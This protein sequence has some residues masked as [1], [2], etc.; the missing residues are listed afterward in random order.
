MNMHQ[1]IKYSCDVYFYD[2]ARRIGINAIAEA[3]RKFGLGETYGFEVPGEKAGLVPTPDWKRATRGEPW[4]QG[5][6]VIAGIGQG[7]LLATPLQ[8]AVMTARLA[9]GGHAVKPR[10]TRAVGGQL[11]P[12]PRPASLGVSETA[13][14][15]ACDGMNAVSNEA[16]AQLFARAFPIPVW[17]SPAR[18]V[19][20]RFAGSAALSVRP[21]SCEMKIFRGGFAT[22]RFLYVSRRC[23]HPGMPCRSSSN[24]AGRA[25]ALRHLSRGTSCAR[26]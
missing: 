16:G 13:L 7:Y 3:A 6:T 22:M 9:N 24:M 10:L 2:V 17:S 23:T 19:P 4:H 26:F 25:P 1:A 5:E 8:L 21:V 15:I 14:K 20:R 18:P 12:T 11:L